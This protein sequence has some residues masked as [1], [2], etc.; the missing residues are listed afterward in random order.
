MFG[1]PFLSE[2]ARYALTLGYEKRGSAFQSLSYVA[3]H[4]VS[5]RKRHTAAKGNTARREGQHG[6]PRKAKKPAMFLCS[7]QQSPE[8]AQ[9]SAHARASIERRFREERDA[10]ERGLTVCTFHSAGEEGME[11]VAMP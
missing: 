9:A 11:R 3:H 4:S 1:K 2:D 5:F 7:R 8:L 6:T 10:S